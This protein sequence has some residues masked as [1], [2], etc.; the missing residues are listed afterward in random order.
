MAVSGVPTARGRHPLLGHC[1]FLEETPLDFV[2]AL[3]QYGDLV[4]IFIGPR[5]VYV[6]NSP[7]LIRQVFV[8]EARE[9]D[10]GALFDELRVHLGEGL[11][12]SSGDFHR[13]QRRLAQP[14]FHADRID[15][16]AATMTKQADAHTESWEPGKPIELMNAI[17]V[18][19]RDILL[20][21][22]F[23][24][25]P[26]PGTLDAI[27]RWMSLKHH[28]MARSLSP[29]SAWS[30]RL[31]R[32][33]RPHRPAQRPTEEQHLLELR[34]LLT[35]AVVQYRTESADRGDLLSMLLAAR[36]P[37][38][39]EGMGD[40]EVCDE[41][42]TLFVAGVGTVSAALAWAFHEVARHPS[43]EET[44]RSEV[45]SVLPDGRP[46]TAADIP[47]L[48]CT[49]RVLK[50]VLRLHPVWLLM[51]RT[52]HPVQLGAAELTPDSEVFV[53]PHALHRDPL[54]FP[55]PDRFDPDRWLPERSARLPRGAFIPFGSG[56]R[57][58]IGE[59]FA[60]TEMIIVLATAAGRLRM[61]HAPGQLVRP[62]VGTVTRPDGLLMIPERPLRRTASGTGE[63]L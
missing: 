13:R 44:L 63:D 7:E 1:T 46:A 53:S 31:P 45:R 47:R 27:T 43:V 28:A 3:R 23:A 59:S 37:K 21:T 61:R 48:P 54:L 49:R 38:T 50:E 26:P 56:N 58:C 18:L 29:A 10:K 8:T 22:V 42:L 24:V 33:L 15:R 25:D 57:L 12:T 9:F 41:L 16:Y 20:R 32:L 30:E 17:D 55:D 62:R 36:H 11:V 35:Q 39:G 34:Q 60:W 6:L 51:R 2:C 40:K 5:P 19:A 4:R 14:A 52:L